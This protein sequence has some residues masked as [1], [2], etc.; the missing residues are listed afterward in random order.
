MSIQLKELIDLTVPQNI[1]ISV[2]SP[3]A[4]FLIL[5]SKFP[6]LEIIPIIS[7]LSLSDAGKTEIFFHKKLVR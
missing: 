2:I 1:L 5:N 7:S 6:N 3:I 4:A